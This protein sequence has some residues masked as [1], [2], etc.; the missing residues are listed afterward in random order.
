MQNVIENLDLLSSLDIIKWIPFS[1]ISE[2]IQCVK[3]KS[4]KQGQYLIKQGDIGD[5]FYIVKSGILEIFSNQNE[6]S[7]KKLV[8]REDYFGESA[9]IGKN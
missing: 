8:F 9:L 7:F 6:N 5:D 4:W 2:V 3:E 1:R